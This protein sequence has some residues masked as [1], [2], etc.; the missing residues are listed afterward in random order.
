MMDNK[1]FGYI[2][3]STL[4]QAEKGYGLKMQQQAIEKYCTP[5]EEWGLNA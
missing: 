2:R 4:T 1:V 5:Y 3:V